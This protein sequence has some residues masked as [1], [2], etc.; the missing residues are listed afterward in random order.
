MT[1]WCRGCFCTVFKEDSITVEEKSFCKNNDCVQS[2]KKKQNQIKECIVCRKKRKQKDM[3]RDNYCTEKCEKDVSKLKCYCG[4]PVSTD[5]A[6]SIEY[7]FCDKH[8][9]DI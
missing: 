8:A 2:Y 4:K 1:D 5:S 7:R 3:V 6:D 9:D